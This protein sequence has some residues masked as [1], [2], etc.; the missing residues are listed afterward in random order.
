MTQLSLSLDAPVSQSRSLDLTGDA[1]GFVFSA[2]DD[3][4]PMRRAH[5][6]IGK[7]IGRYGRQPAWMT[8]APSEA[9]VIGGEVLGVPV[10]PVNTSAQLYRLG[11]AQEA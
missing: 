9:A 10:F 5:I 7:Y 11:I 8:C 6:A 4:D 3:I 2:K 1:K